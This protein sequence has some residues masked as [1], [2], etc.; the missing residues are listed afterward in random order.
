MFIGHFGIAYAARAASPRLSLGTAF[1]AAQF[2]D[3]LWPTLLLLGIETVRIQP[4]ATAVTPLVF[5]HYPVSHS[6]LAVAG[7]AVLLAALHFA[8]R[9]DVRSALVVAALVASH[10]VLDALVHAP[11]LPL[12]PGGGARIGLGLW[13]SLP[14]TLAGEGLLFA[15]GLALYLRRTRPVDRTGTWATSALAALLVV[16]HAGNLAG[17]PPPSVPA[18]AWVGHAQWLLV[19]LA[20]WADAHRRPGR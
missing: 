18:I 10:W 11:D 7:W 20:Y 5:E 6:L 14:A 13:N 1:L 2:I 8:G 16:I 3:L 12:A 9:R 17:P 19:A 15:G 4:G